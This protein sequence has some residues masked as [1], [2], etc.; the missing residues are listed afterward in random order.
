MPK[1][2]TAATTST[3]PTDSLLDTEETE[4][5]EVDF[6]ELYWKFTNEHTIQ[7]R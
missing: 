3:A 1:P 4:V 7:M 2:G 6:H 5:K